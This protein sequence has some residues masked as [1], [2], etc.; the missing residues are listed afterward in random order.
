MPLLPSPVLLRCRGGAVRR[1]DCHRLCTA[2]H[3]PAHRQAHQ[4]L[5]PAWIQFAAAR[6]TRSRLFLDIA[7]SPVVAVVRFSSNPWP[8]RGPSFHL[9]V[10]VL[11]A[12][13]I[14]PAVLIALRRTE[15]PALRRCPRLWAAP[16]RAGG[17]LDDSAKRVHSFFA[18][19]ANHALRHVPSVLPVS[20]CCGGPG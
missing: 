17:G 8:R 16:M 14:F 7:F 9:I 3:S 10:Q 20:G 6:Y 19:L 18:V 13:W 1:Y 5:H 11:T 15:I 12:V 4:C 2:R